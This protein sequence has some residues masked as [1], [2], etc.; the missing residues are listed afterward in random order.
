MLNLKCYI[1]VAI[2]DNTTMIIIIFSNVV[3]MIMDTVIF[4]NFFENDNTTMIIIIFSN[5]VIMIMDTV[6]F[7]NFFE[8]GRA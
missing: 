5:M 1:K 3:I 2:N 8:S 4:L 6:I 7:L